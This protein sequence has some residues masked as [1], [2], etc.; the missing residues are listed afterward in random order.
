M[1]RVL[2]AVCLGAAVGAAVAAWPLLRQQSRW[3]HAASASVPGESAGVKTITGD[4]VIQA[5]WTARE[6]G[7][8]ADAELRAYEAIAS[9]TAT[10]CRMAAETALLTGNKAPLPDLL[11]RW[12]SVNGQQA[13]AWLA[14]HPDILKLVIQDAGPAW[15]AA[16]PAGYAAW[17]PG[18]RE[19]GGLPP[20]WRF[21]P[22]SHWLAPWDL[23]A[24]MAVTMG[25][26]KAAGFDQMHLG[27]LELEPFIRTAKEAGAM[28]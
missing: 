10:Q 1:K 20:E 22:A 25:K 17:L 19:G 27:A 7:S 21:Y 5:W 8:K 26:I 13:F 4:A 6:S 2:L 23:P 9:L 24:A 3:S 12:A 11:T 18:W 15:A 28:A 16:D 14:G